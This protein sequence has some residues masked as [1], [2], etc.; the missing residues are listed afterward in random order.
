MVTLELGVV[1]GEIVWDGHLLKLSERG[2][3]GLRAVL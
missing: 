2:P 1:K 3:A